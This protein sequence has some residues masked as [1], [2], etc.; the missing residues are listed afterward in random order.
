MHILA[1]LTKKK[2][3]KAAEPTDGCFGKPAKRAKTEEVSSFKHTLF[4]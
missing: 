4:F 2:L 1:G 3:S